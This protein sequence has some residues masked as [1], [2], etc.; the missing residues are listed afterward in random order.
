MSCL[1][2]CRD[3]VRL[4]SPPASRAYCDVNRGP[5]EL[6]P[7][8]VF[9]PSPW[10]RWI[11]RHPRVQAGLGVIPRIVRD[12]AEIYRSKLLPDEAKT[13]IEFICYISLITWRSDGFWWKRPW[14]ASAR[15]LWSIA[16]PCLRRLSVP[17]HR[18]GRPLWR[19]RAAAADRVGR[20]RLCT[21]GFQRGAQFALCRRFH[22]FA[23]W[24]GR[25]VGCYALQIEINRSL[26]SG[27]RAVWRA[28]SPL[29]RF[30]K[31]G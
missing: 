16:I 17:G 18:A 6:D 2:A 28:E 9:R 22:H 27:R 1:P 11:H 3:W 25:H 12:G 29:A 14:R 19:L 23:L 8:H 5:A 30:Q 15:P 7:D 13:R 21:S 4:C 31:N 10:W 24:A 26:V 20:K